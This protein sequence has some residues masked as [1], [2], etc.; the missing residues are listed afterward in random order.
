MAA[1]AATINAS[2]ANGADLKYDKTSGLTYNDSPFSFEN[3]LGNSDLWDFSGDLPILKN[4][5]GPQ[6]NNLPGYIT[7]E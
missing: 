4:V 7:D 5:G 2:G 1:H 6:S 3:V